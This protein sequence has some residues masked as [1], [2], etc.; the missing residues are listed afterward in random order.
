MF[1]FHFRSGG[2]GGGGCPPQIDDAGVANTKSPGSSKHRKQK[3]TSF[4]VTA[5]V[6]DNTPLA[7]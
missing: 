2:G 3:M 6:A 4:S 7:R 1:C 5:Q